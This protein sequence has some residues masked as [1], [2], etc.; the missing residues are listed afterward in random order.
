M[1]ENKIAVLAI[2]ETHLDERSMN[3]INR[4]FHKR[5]RI[6][7]S[8]DPENPT[9]GRGVAVVLNKDLTRWNEV[10]TRIIIPGRA[11]LLSLPLKDSSTVNI[12]AIYAPNTP[13]ENANFWA[14]LL[15]IWEETSPLALPDIMLGDFNIVE[16]ALDQLPPHRDN[17]QAVNN[18]VTFKALHTLRDGWRH[19]HPDV[20]SYSYTQQATQ[21][22]SRID[23]IYVTEPIYTHS[24]NW[25]IN[26]T[27]INTDHCL[28]S[29]EFSN[30]GVP[31][32]GKGRWSIPLYLVKH[33]KVLQIV[34]TLGLDLQQCIQ[35]TQ[36]ENWTAHE[37]PQTLFYSFKKTLTKKICDF[38]C[39]ETPKM[40]RRI[41][42]LKD[43]LNGILNNS[44]EPIEEIQA[45]PAYIKERIK[46]LETK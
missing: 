39:T 28:T 46:Q 32:I 12:L 10:K 15:S 26:L 2:Q 22:R 40:D 21:S 24:R 14:S 1:Q 16:E 27:P 25:D 17:A 29:M 5:L 38:S 44:H 34:E 20:K 42:D 41:A 43:D 13:Q 23:R 30:P 45:K 9:A 31:Y 8:A 37:N 18:L 7:N 36:G 3:E 19:N 4:T 33:R 35:E 11:I 6:V